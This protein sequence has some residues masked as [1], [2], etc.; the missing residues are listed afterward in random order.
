MDYCAYICAT[1]AGLILFCV[2]MIG[3]SGMPFALNPAVSV[4]LEPLGHADRYDNAYYVAMI[5]LGVWLVLYVSARI[6]AV[7]AL[8]LIL[9]KVLAV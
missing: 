3:L 2:G 7:L 1:I 5:A 9:I 6:A 4:L 8:A